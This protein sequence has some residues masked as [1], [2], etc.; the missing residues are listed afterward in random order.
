MENSA[1]NDQAASLW[2]G[3]AESILSAQAFQL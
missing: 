3:R 1:D 2:A